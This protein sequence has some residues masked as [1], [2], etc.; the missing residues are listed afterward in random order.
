MTTLAQRL[1]HHRTIAGLTIKEVAKRL[2]ISPS[3]YRDWEKGS[4]IKGEPY[5]QLAKV[6]NISVYELLSGTKG[7]MG[8]TL[9]ALD[10]VKKALYHLE[11]TLRKI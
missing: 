2:E 6:F 11:E 3:T 5:L 10:S 7:D 1:K 4:L 9:V 8:E